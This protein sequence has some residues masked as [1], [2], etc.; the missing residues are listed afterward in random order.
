MILRTAGN[1]FLAGLEEEINDNHTHGLSICCIPSPML[2]RLLHNIARHFHPCFMSSCCLWCQTTFALDTVSGG[3]STW[4]HSCL[5]PACLFLSLILINRYHISDST[6]CI[7]SFESCSTYVSHLSMENNTLQT[8]VQLS[9][10]MTTIQ[11]YFSPLVLN[12]FFI[13][14]YKTFFCLTTPL[15]SCADVDIHGPSWSVLFWRKYVGNVQWLYKSRSLFKQHSI[16]KIP[17]TT[18]T[19]SCKTQ[20]TTSGTLLCSEINGNVTVYKGM[21]WTNTQ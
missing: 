13:Y 20:G 18:P 8:Y 11:K 10:Q 7:S 4:K 15:F 2:F 6:S 17:P 19:W 21:W 14:I 16:I 3:K 12:F 1:L 9:Y 5:G